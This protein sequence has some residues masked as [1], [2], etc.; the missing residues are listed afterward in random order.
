MTDAQRQLNDVFAEMAELISIF[1]DVYNS[2]FYDNFNI[3]CSQRFTPFIN[4]I[5]IKQPRITEKAI[6]VPLYKMY[7]R[8]CQAK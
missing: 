7:M 2:C 4:N 5:I 8:Y 1:K 6:N 3:Y